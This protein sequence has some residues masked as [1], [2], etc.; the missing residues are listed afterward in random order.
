M[1]EDSIIE[2]LHSISE[3]YS[4]NSSSNEAITQA[5][6]YIE[7]LKEYHSVGT[8]NY[9]RELNDL[10]VGK[11]PLFVKRSFTNFYICPHCSTNETYNPVYSQ[12]EHCSK[13]G[14]RLLWKH[15]ERKEN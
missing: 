4:D 3:M 14:G 13:C 15:K 2:K 5:I 9:V 6:S 8:V 12:A 10:Y 11:E 7:E 1:S